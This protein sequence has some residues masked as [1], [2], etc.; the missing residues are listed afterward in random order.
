MQALDARTVPAHL[1]SLT[2][3]NRSFSLEKTRTSGHP[4][5]ALSPTIMKQ[6]FPRLG[7]VVSLAIVFAFSASQ[8]QNS[9]LNDPEI[10]RKLGLSV[11]QVHSLRAAFDLTDDGLLSLSAAKIQELIRDLEHPGIEKH[12]RDEEFRVLRMMDEHGKIPPDGLMQALEHRKHVGGDEDLFPV[13]PDPSTNVPTSGTPGPLAAGIQ[14]NGWTWLGPGNIGGRVRSILIHPT[15]TNIMWC[16]GV[17]GGIWKT[18]NS[19]ASWFPLNDFMANLAVSCM[20]MDPADPNT[21]YAG[22]GEPTYNADAIRGAGIFKTVDGGATWFQLSATATSSYLYVSRLSIDPNNSLIMLAATRSGIFRTTNGG[23]NWTQTSST[24]MNDVDFH[25]T[26]SSQ[27]I[28]SGRAGNAFYSSNG[29]VSWTAATG[30]AGGRVEVAYCRSSPNVVYASVD[31]SSGQLY[32]SSDGGH[33]YALRNT[34]NNYLSAQGWY[35]NALWADPTTTNIVIVAGLDIWRST[36][37]GATLTKISQWFSAPNSAHADH[38]FIVNHPGFDGATI[39]TVYF[40]NDG[41]IYRA[42]NVYTVSLT[43]GWQELNNN[44]GLTQFYGGAGNTNTGVIVGGT[45]DNGDLRYTP[46]NGTE[47]WNAWNGGDGGF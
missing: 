12:I 27:A 24:E 22:T 11:Q 8:A 30:L 32:S 28:A 44:L 2:F 33:T 7:V 45:Q 43:S 31:N 40:A 41:G 47:G 6:V 1:L 42:N 4:S 18:T 17:D 25:P 5:T 3:T 29:G 9:K 34:G 19:A 37:G 39:R 38:H 13:A 20:V 35:D 15:I 10:G 14:T 26:D 16:G 21:I 23:T 46:A 36:D